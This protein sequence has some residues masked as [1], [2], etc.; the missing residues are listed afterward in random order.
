M[1]FD[2]SLDSEKDKWWGGVIPALGLNYQQFR[3]RIRAISGT[4]E[5]PEATPT[6]ADLDPLF[7]DDDK[8]LGEIR[9]DLA[10]AIEEASPPESASAPTS[11]ISEAST[12]PPSSPAKTPSDINAGIARS[13]EQTD[14]DDMLGREGIA[15]EIFA[16]PPKLD[17][18][19]DSSDTSQSATPS[20]R[21][22]P[23]PATEKPAPYRPPSNA[24]S[25]I[26]AEA[27]PDPMAK[28]PA[29]KAT[30]PAPYSLDKTLINP[31]FSFNKY[32][33]EASA[34]RP[35]GSTPTPSLLNIAANMYRAQ[36]AGNSMAP[37]ADIPKE[38]QELM[39]RAIAALAR[40]SAEDPSQPLPEWA[41]DVLYNMGRA[42][43][44]ADQAKSGDT[45]IDAKY[46]DSPWVQSW[47]NTFLRGATSMPL[48]QQFADELRK[49]GVP[50]PADLRVAQRGPTWIGKTG[51]D[52]AASSLTEPQTAETLQKYGIDPT[53]TYE[54]CG[55]LA[56]SAM[57]KAGTGEMKFTFGAVFEAAKTLGY[58]GDIGDGNGWRGPDK[59][60]EFLNSYG[61]KSEAIARADTPET[62]R[63]LVQDI[64]RG[65][66]VTITNGTH[67]FVA[68]DYNPQTG[69]FF[70]GT[71]G[72]ALRRGR[73][74]MTPSEIHGLGDGRFTAIRMLE[75]TAGVPLGSKPAT[76][77]PFS[78][79]YGEVDYTSPDALNGTED[80]D[81]EA[82][83]RKAARQ[84]GLDPDFVLWLIDHEGGRKNPVRINNS[85][86]QAFGP[87]QLH[88]EGVGAEFKQHMK[89][90]FGVDADVRDPRWWKA[91][92][93]YALDTAARAKNWNP[94]EAATA[95][96]RENEGFI[97]PTPVGISD[98]AWAYAGYNR[99]APSARRS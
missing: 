17:T 6:P 5:S 44:Q 38:E 73:A 65:K 43:W 54:V 15:A 7:P 48:Q 84:R 1:T 56:A 25:V 9:Q 86:V 27:R 59:M 24:S 3:A 87:L 29:V 68:T 69:Q 34:P 60:A 28:S 40:G 63:S 93:E 57:L 97:D 32:I 50:A 74:W 58:W 96:G 85:G 70:V 18:R 55:P 46:A 2:S 33:A 92:M 41:L 51:R 14:Q 52:I 89:R 22:K 77:K 64:S 35:D 20:D 26:D 13:T 12:P 4:V 19:S 45:R 21:P 10:T 78:T 72:E 62:L 83:A 71:T 95:R 36:R 61:V 94:W 91:A 81:I 80:G 11:E 39:A 75:D 49:T 30:A 31:R 76:T 67:Y 82:F 8:L 23:P 90:T 16:S 66:P 98:E 37:Y 53:Y 47:V 42:A 99:G 79:E 88:V